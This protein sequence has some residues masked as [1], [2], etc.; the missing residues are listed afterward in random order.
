MIAEVTMDLSQPSLM[1]TIVNE[2]VLG[3]NNNNIS[4]V[5]LILH[6]G[7]R[8][9]LFIF[10]GGISGILSGVFANICSQN[11]AN[12]MRKDCFQKIMSLSFEQTDEFSTG[13]LIT[14]VTNDV[15]QVQNLIAQLIRGFVRTM[16][17][18]IG[19][20]ICIIY[21]D[22]SFLTVILC[23]IPP[24]LIAIF[25]IIRKANPM[26]FVLQKKLD[27]VNGIM[28]E[29]VTGARVVKAYNKEAYETDRFCVGNDELIDT[30]LRVLKLFSYMSPILNI[31]LNLS[32]VG[33]IYVSGFQLRGTG[34]TP[35]TV[36]AAITYTSQIIHSMMMLAN[37]FQTLSRGLASNQRLME[38]LNTEAIIRDGGKQESK[39]N[40]GE[41]VFEQVSFVY[42]DNPEEVILQDINLTIA[43]GE[44]I[45]IL[46]STG[47][48]KSSLVNLIP[49][50]YDVNQG[51]ILI[52]GVDIK[53]YQL[54]GLRQGIGIALQK[55][56]LFSTS[57]KE[58]I[59]FGK[60]DASE[61]EVTNAADI[62]Q[63]SDFIAQTQEGYDTLVA[64]KGM[65]LSGGQKQRIAISRAVIKG[66]KILIFDDSTSALDLT[67]E[68]NLYQALN[69][70]YGH[71]TKIIVAQRIA[72]VKNA[73]RIV[74]MEQGR[75]VSIGNHEK[76]MKESPIY[77]DIYNSQLKKAGDIIG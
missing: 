17:L 51:R 43:A 18:L 74:V 5:N 8:M 59:R 7:I 40:R 63:A 66:A 24:V 4:D 14:R 50:F 38:V 46:G 71:M 13:S 1:K 56:E 77:Q 32:I 30:Q 20:T 3:L 12:D 57:I 31:V 11:V 65:S 19:G 73:D 22:I 47:S 67:T 72:S 21:L 37:I 70:S 75:I 25:Y 6:T 48:G 68:A 62:A 54:K 34:V 60:K 61:V 39:I 76:L 28:Q 35:G 58:N 26:F 55:S 64:E 15:T 42:P 9:I 53:D 52:D 23:A 44:T 33:I 29:N 27:K 41:I 36:M 10:L 69:K 2:G 16:T 49:R 45:A